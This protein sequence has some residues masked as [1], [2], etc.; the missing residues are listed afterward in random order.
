MK[1]FTAILFVLASTSVFANTVKVTSFVLARNSETLAELCGVV[2]G[3]LT[4][5][6]YVK[7]AVDPYGR[8]PGTYNTVAG[9]DGKFCV[10]VMTYN[11]RAEASVFGNKK[12]SFASLK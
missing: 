12:V 2:V 8:R 10:V 1:L 9:V 3:T 6:T 11:G 7:V 4:A 5:P